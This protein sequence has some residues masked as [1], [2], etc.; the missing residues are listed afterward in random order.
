MG[1]ETFNYIDSL[2]ATNPTSTDNVNEGDNHIRG[3]KTALKNSLPNIN[4]AVTSTD[5]ELNILDG[6]TTTTTQL[7]YLNTATSNVQ[8][9]INAKQDQSTVL[10][11]T[12]ASYTTA[13]ET[14]LAGIEAG[15]TADQ[16]WGDITGT[17]S[18]Q[19]DLQSALD[20]KASASHTHTEYDAAGTGLAMAIALG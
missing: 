4:G 8:S 12:T 9:Q 16:A 15:A 13:E 1:I 18:N 6:V 17:L 10:D 2:V 5:E 20:G 3:I 14:K 7:N 11:N 19:T